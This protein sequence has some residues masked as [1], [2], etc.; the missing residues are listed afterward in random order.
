MRRRRRLAHFG[1]QRRQRRAARLCRRDRAG[2]PAGRGRRDVGTRSPRRLQ[3]P[4]VSHDPPRLGVL[5][6]GGRVARPEMRVVDGERL[7]ATRRD[8]QRQKRRGDA[9]TPPEEPGFERRPNPRNDARK[10]DFRTKRCRRFRMAQ[11]RKNISLLLA[12]HIV[13]GISCQGRLWVRRSRLSRAGHP[14]RRDTPRFSDR[15]LGFAVPGST[16][17]KERQRRIRERHPANLRTRKPN[18]RW[19]G[20]A[21]FADDGAGF[22]KFMSERSRRCPVRYLRAAAA[23]ALVVAESPRAPRDLRRTIARAATN[24][25]RP[26]FPSPPP[27]SPRDS[28]RSPAGCTGR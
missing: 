4:M 8:R 21:S 28:R 10:G 9:D 26:T 11:E 22:K 16:G 1:A 3:R 18:G 14:N 19:S 25:W 6:G 13:I 5:R 12:I 17:S 7:L 20:R 27:R 24:C 15:F 23:A 2:P